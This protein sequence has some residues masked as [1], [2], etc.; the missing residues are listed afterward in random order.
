MGKD[1]V[2]F[3]REAREFR[4]HHCNAL[5]L[6]AHVEE[7]RTCQLV[8]RTAR[9]EFLGNCLAQFQCFVANRREGR[10]AFWQHALAD[11]R[12]GHRAREAEHFGGGIGGL[13]NLQRGVEHHY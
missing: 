5:D 1:Q 13:R 3:L 2:K 7:W 9:V 8:A 11:V 10:E 4:N 12:V 6:P